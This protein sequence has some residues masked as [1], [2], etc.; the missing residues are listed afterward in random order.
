M[1]AFFIILSILFV[2]AIISGQM[3]KNSSK[4]SSAQPASS[5]SAPTQPVAV[6]Q[7]LLRMMRK[8]LPSVDSFCDLFDQMSSDE[9]FLKYLRQSY[10]SLYGVMH[11]DEQTIKASL[12]KYLTNIFA[13]DVATTSAKLGHEVTLKKNDDCGFGALLFKINSPEHRND[14]VTTLA[15]SF[16]NVVARDFDSMLTSFSNLTKKIC[17]DDGLV[18]PELLDGD[19]VDYRRDFLKAL[20]SYSTTLANIDGRLTQTEVQ[21]LNALDEKVKDCDDE[22]VSDDEDSDENSEESSEDP[23]DNRTPEPAEN[24]KSAEEELNEL[25][26]L[27]SVKKEVTTFKNYLMVQKAREKQGLPMPPTSYHLVFSGNPGTGKTT[28]AR[29]MAKIFKEFGILEKGHMVETD[30]ADLVA[31]Y[32]GQTAIKTDEIV[33]SALDGVLFVD[34]AYTL[35]KSNDNDYGQEAI[36]TLLK[37]MEDDR[38]RLVVIVAGYTNEIREFVQSNPGLSS[39]FNRYIEFP[40]YTLDELKEIFNL[41]LK[42]YRYQLDKAART[43]LDEVIASAMESADKNHFGNGRF[44]RNLFEKVVERQANRLASS[45]DLSKENLCLLTREDVVG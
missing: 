27:A 5:P 37:R 26:G 16:N 30:R 15:K 38:K 24:E 29:I 8:L 36:D 4:P 41:S 31:G 3:K 1:S 10:E 12:L 35:S 14:S 33:D 18:V 44:V 32:V 13:A 42:K 40:D 11:K 2:L 43:A 9:D 20:Y 28:I 19:Y 34:E 25:I 17:G 22:D 21:W 45:E 39:R 23:N 6:D 7:E